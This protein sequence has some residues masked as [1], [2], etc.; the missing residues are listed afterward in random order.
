MLEPEG[1][2]QETPPVNRILDRPK[3]IKRVTEAYQYS[4]R[5]IENQQ[6]TSSRDPSRK[7]DDSKRKSVKI[8]WR[9]SGSVI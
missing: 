1:D 6:H 4:I 2:R 9:A 3:T 8:G 5:T 7:I